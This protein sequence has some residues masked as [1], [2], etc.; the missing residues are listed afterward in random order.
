MANPI[1]E[2][3]LQTLPTKPGVYLFKSQQQEV[4]YVGKAINLRV[5]VRSYFRPKGQVG[6]V[7]TMVSHIADLDYIVTGSEL[8]ALV[9]ECNLIK[10]HRP[11]YNVRL[12]DDKHYPYIKV[13]LDEDWPRVYIVRRVADDRAR[14][15]GP[16]TDSRS[17]W[18]TLELLQK[19]FPYR[20][21]T[22]T[23][24][25]E[26]KRACLNYH[27]HRCVGPCIGMVSREDYL[28]V[29]HQVCLFLDG[30]QEEIIK[31]MRRKMEAAAEKLEFERAAFLRD[32]IAAVEKVTERQRIIST[33]IKDED[34]VA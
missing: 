32:Q 14:Y 21:C 22:Q 27:I 6:K 28:S 31:E 13:S 29:I 33:A 4:I 7:A 25:G 15:F 8:E 11:K 20:S 9:L 18:K 12:R 10:K 16:Y 23:I 34:I 19:M 24:T 26:D 30:R 17:V 5:R 1:I 3:R 2:N